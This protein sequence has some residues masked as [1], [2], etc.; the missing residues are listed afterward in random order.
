MILYLNF[1][2]KSS[3][4][5]KN[6]GKIP[7]AGR[8][9]REEGG[10]PVLRNLGSTALLA[11]LLLFA[12]RCETP[13]QADEPPAEGRGAR[14]ARYAEMLAVVGRAEARDF[15]SVTDEGQTA[16]GRSLKLVHLNR[17]GER[18]RW[19]V[20][21][22]GQ[23][24]GD[25]HAG[26]DALLGLIDDI[27]RNPGH[28][29]ED[30]DLWIMPMVNPDGAEAGTRA[31]SR[32]EDL[33]RDHVLLS[34]PE[35][36]ALHGVARRVRPHVSV[37]CHEFTR[38]S[39]DYEE[40]GWGEWPII[41]MDT[42]NYP[43]LDEGVVKAG[44]RWCERVAP[45]LERA[46]HNYTRYYL[47]D[48]PPNNEWRHSTPE[49]GDARNGLATYGGLS[50]IIESGFKRR[51]AD[52]QADLGRRVAAY[53]TLL[54]QFLDDEGPRASDLKAIEEA[55]RRPLPDFLPTNFFWGNVGRRTTPVRVVELA[56]GR[57]RVVLTPNFMHDL[58]IKKSVARP[59]GYAVEPRAAAVFRPVLDRL[60]VAYEVS[61]APRTLRAETCRLLR[62]EDQDDPVHDRYGG[63]QIV[64][65]AE[66]AGRL[67]PPG[68]LLIALEG[69]Q[70]AG[71]A[72][73]QL[74]EPCMLYGPYQKPAFRE[75]LGPDGVLPVARVISE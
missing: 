69:G 14:P 7:R 1:M 63:R 70:S 10:P 34:Q 42:A 38:D 30:V 20:F 46:G 37:D 23:Q 28:L 59:Q 43:L 22:F 35:T 68:T 53:T 31:N 51:A 73:V 44:E 75:L 4:E 8:I 17:G 2:A 27:A 72:A 12:A 61:E 64:E 15:I 26:K 57:T 11:T 48:V 18:A 60:G 40:K 36:R 3:Q 55:G 33:N 13:S 71:V 45:A 67:F 19:R 6:L 58:V 49:A 54:R 65:R 41:E 9:P 56:T 32:G 16:E 25:E 39:K 29:P 24:H 47:G 5:F 21:F 74:L 66:A 62:I 52:P 50:F